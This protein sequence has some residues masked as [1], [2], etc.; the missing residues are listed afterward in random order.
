MLAPAPASRSELRNLRAIYDTRLRTRALSIPKSNQ[1]Q[2]WPDKRT[3][4]K[5]HPAT[6]LD[7]TPLRPS[8]GQVAHFTRERLKRVSRRDIGF[9][10]ALISACG[11]RMRSARRRRPDRSPAGYFRSDCI[12]GAFEKFTAFLRLIAIEVRPMACHSPSRVRS[13]AW[14][15]AALNFAKACSIGS[16]GRQIDQL[17]ASH[18]DRLPD[19]S[20]LWLLRLSSRAISSGR[21]VGASICST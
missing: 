20:G 18:G 9:Y 3:R 4:Y 1:G 6:P 11:T 14:R 12:A 15:S 21:Q 5:N 2:R 8:T 13:A 7:S 19:A 10:C 16:V 17:R